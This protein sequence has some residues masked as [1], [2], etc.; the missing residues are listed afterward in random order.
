M[1]ARAIAECCKVNEGSNIVLKTLGMVLIL[2]LPY[3]Q[4]NSTWEEKAPD[5]DTILQKMPKN[6]KNR[7][8]HVFLYQQTTQQIRYFYKEEGGGA[9]GCL[10][11]M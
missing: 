10:K 9:Y 4:L 6:R 1:A 8:N 11:K 3:N 2:I 7:K 5:L